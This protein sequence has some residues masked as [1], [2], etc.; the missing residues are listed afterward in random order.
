MENNVNQ[1]TTDPPKNWFSYQIGRF[2]NWVKEWKEAFAYTRN[3]LQYTKKDVAVDTV[4]SLR[5]YAISGAV[6]GIA[7]FKTTFP[8]VFP[9]IKS[10]FAKVGTAL[11]AIW[12]V[13]TGH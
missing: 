1:T 5:S 6:G 13:A 9:M 10:F 4:S 3:P 8:W 12:H 7:W 11:A 2:K